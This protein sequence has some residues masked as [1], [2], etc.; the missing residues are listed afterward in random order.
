MEVCV[1]IVYSFL[2]QDAQA[3]LRCRICPA[4]VKQTPL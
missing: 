3:Q 1:D 4:K 2:H